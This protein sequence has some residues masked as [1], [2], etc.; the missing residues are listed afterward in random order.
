MRRTTTLTALAALALAPLG[1]AAAPAQ[2]AET[3]D[4]KVATIVVPPKPGAFVTDPVVGTPGDDVIVGTAQA[5]DID[6]AGGND[7]ICGLA[8]A[9]DLAGG[10]GDDRLFGGRDE[11]YS[12]D[13]DY[14]GD[15]VAP[16]PGDDYVD[17][18]HDPQSE[19]LY[20]VDTGY[21]DQVSYAG[22]AGPVVVDLTA[23][24]AT[25]EGT[26][27]IAPVTYGGGIEGS[28]YADQL[29]GQAGP[30]WITAGSGDDIVT[31]EDG[32]DM[33]DADEAT[34]YPSQGDAPQPGDDVVDSGGGN[35]WI[36]GGHGSD[37]LAGGEDDDWVRADDSRGTRVLGGPGRD[38]VG[39][40][41]DLRAEGQGGRDTLWP[42]VD[43]PGLI[44]V[45][46]G[47]GRDTVRL[48][49]ARD[50]REGTRVVIGRTRGI[51]QIGDEHVVRFSSAPRFDLNAMHAGPVTWFG[52]G[53]RD[54]ADLENANRAVRAYG[55]GGNDTITGSWERDVL[56]GGP[57]RDAID[58]SAGRDRCLR[59][60]RLQSC[61]RRR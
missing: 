55:R 53:G 12:P 54:V 6:G 26:D 5:D 37:L 46:G 22:A 11:D 13:D 23:G 21:W 42:Q 4:G 39:G 45:V 59:G 60:E 25:G 18:G 56:D 47:P 35:D 29:T 27:T 40:S 52:T 33:I 1:L 49:V 30:D 41:G 57:G 14:Y 48:D 58:G 16:G 19:D 10:P 20:S 9:D 50:L 31:G 43:G 15:L 24:T 28:A 17:L 51:V 38:T 32:D 36:T 61:E 34:R 44:D 2:A 7:S 8:G 3:C